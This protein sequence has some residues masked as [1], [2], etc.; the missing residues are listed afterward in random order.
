MDDAPSAAYWAKHIRQP[1]RFLDG[2][3][4]LLEASYDHFLEVGPQPILCGMAAKSTEKTLTLLASCK[5]QH[6]LQTFY[7]TMGQLFMK[8]QL[9]PSAIAEHCVV[10]SNTHTCA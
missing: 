8:K 10:H 5:R 6:A 7:H 4:C 9:N 3:Q 1:V 2:M